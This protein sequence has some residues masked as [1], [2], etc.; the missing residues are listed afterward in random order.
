MFLHEI[1]SVFSLLLWGGGILALFAYFI[2]TEDSSNLFLAFVLWA[3]VLISAAFTL[4]QNLKSESILDS[5][6]VFSNSKAIVIRGG[7]QKEILALDL[8]VGD[9]C[10]INEGDKIPADIRIFEANDLTSNNSTLTGESKIIKLKTKCNPN[11][12]KN[13]LESENI[14]FFF[15]M[16]ASG[17]GKGVIIKTGKDT[18][19]GKIAEL[20]NSASES[21]DGHSL[22]NETNKYIKII[23]IIAITVGLGFFLGGVGVGYPM[24]TNI[25]MAIGVIVANV[26]EGLLSCLTVALA[27][28]A[29]ILNTKG[30]MSKQ[31]KS[32]ET[33]GAITCIC[34]DKTGTLTQNRMSVKTLWYDMEFKSVSNQHI[35]LENIE[36]IEMDPKDP[37]FKYL[38]FCAICGSGSS[39]IKTTPEDFPAIVKE[40]NAWQ[41]LNPKAKSTEVQEEVLKLQKQ[42]QPEYDEIYKNNID[43]RL[44]N[45]DAD[46]EGLLKFF[47]KIEN[48]DIIR[49]RFPLVVQDGEEIRIPFT[50]ETKSAGYL[51][52]VNIAKSDAAFEDTSNSKYWLA[53]K[54][55]PEYLIKKCK[56]YL[57]DGRQCNMDN[58][59]PARYREAYETMQAQGLRVLAFAFA[60]LDPKKY[61]DSY[62]FKN[63]TH[64]YP[65]PIGER[66]P[67]FPIDDLCMAGL[68]I[69]EDPPR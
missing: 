51:R 17:K 46:E 53:Y 6:K 47:E 49:E 57:Q 59:F 65:V 36:T 60:K 11:G 56:Y 50:S 43:K 41:K 55:A 42:Y 24:I 64:D 67:N 30:M 3:C 19:M 26:P 37:S 34:A 40:R 62:V 16:C 27:L 32:V 8:V 28:N 54:G 29:K 66:T 5:F 63:D 25:T 31:M 61:N 21:Q 4:S 35:D 18:Y 38:Q 48:I 2:D 52:N 22:E 39:F 13:Y 45:G 12:Y 10:L 58:L 20:A 14:A 44:T 23:S 68:I 7:Q 33:L 69:S 15:T 1:S 9:V